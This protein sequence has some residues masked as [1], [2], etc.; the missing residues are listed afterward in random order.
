MDQQT[1]PKKAFEPLEKAQLAM[2][3]VNNPDFEQE[4]DAYVSGKDYDE[5]SVNFFKE[6]IA[7][8]QKLQQEGGKLLDTGGQILSLVVNALAKSWQR[9]GGENNSR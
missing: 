6:Q 8:Q 4:I 1:Q 9:T 7:L 3:L 5:H 2:R